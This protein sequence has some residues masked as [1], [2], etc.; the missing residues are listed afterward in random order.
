M[1]N[2]T[3]SLLFVL[4]LLLILVSGASLGRALW[5]YRQQHAL[6]PSSG[7]QYTVEPGRRAPALWSFAVNPYS[8][9]AQLIDDFQPLLDHLGLPPELGRL[10]LEASRDFAAFEAKIT[11]QAPDFIRPNPWQALEAMH[12]G[13]TVIAMAGDPQDFRGLIVARKDRAV[14]RVEQLRGQK[15]AAPSPTALAAC[16]MPQWFLHERGIDVLHDLDTRYVGSQESAIMSA[17]LGEAYVA[18]SW[19]SPWRQFQA[20]YPQKAAELEIVWET[21]PLVNNPVMVHA[22][23]PAVVREKVSRALYA[24]DQTASGRALLAEAEIA[25]F[26]PATDA[27][28]LPVRQFIDRFEHAVR[29][30]LTQP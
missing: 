25:F 29:P 27:D 19:P 22:R 11:R 30:V 14:R 13:Y 18:M 7:P 17:F 16:L 23:V 8:N 5:Q 4:G 15:V 10:H 21:A 9:P 3:R 2:R 20:K 6:P 12:H 1:S 28:Y 24:L 26:R